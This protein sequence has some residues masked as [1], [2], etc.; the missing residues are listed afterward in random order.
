MSIK[1]EE[2]EETV[3]LRNSISN[4]N[5]ANKKSQNPA[6]STLTPNT[7]STNLQ[8]LST[9]SDIVVVGA[10]AI[11]NGNGNGNGNNNTT[12]NTHA[13]LTPKSSLSLPNDDALSASGSEEGTTSNCGSVTIGTCTII[14]NPI[15]NCE[16]SQ[17]IPASANDANIA[18]NNTPTTTTTAASATTTPAANTGNNLLVT[19]I[20]EAKSRRK[21]SVQGKWTI[22]FNTQK[23]KTTKYQSQLIVQSNKTEKQVNLGIFW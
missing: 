12:H 23:K 5:I 9:T 10:N 2:D 8:R 15:G 14:E 21:L 3:E 11:S 4:S 18:S 13:S 1:E 17:S 20:P 19:D 6:D 7:S 22:V 16:S